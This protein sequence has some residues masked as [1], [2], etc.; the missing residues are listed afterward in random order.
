MIRWFKRRRPTLPALPTLAIEDLIILRW[1]GLTLAK[2]DAMPIL[3][4]ID[5]REGFHKARGMG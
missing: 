3:A 2:W 4:K 1:A 5:V